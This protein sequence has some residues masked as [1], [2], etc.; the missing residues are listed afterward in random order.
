M[1]TTAGRELGAVR[2]VYV[3]ENS[4]VVEAK[5]FTA[6]EIG[7]RA[8]RQLASDGAKSRAHS[9][10]ERGVVKR[11]PKQVMHSELLPDRQRQEMGHVLG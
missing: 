6:R 1:I 3:N 4:G 5:R 2:D 7:Q 9:F 8:W 10:F 11:H